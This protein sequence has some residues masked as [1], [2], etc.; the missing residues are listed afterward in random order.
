M[1]GLPQAGS[2]AY[3]LL[4]QGLVCHGYYKTETPGFWQHTSWPISF[5]L[6]VDD[7]DIKYI[8]KQQALHL[9][10][11]LKN[12]SPLTLTRPAWDYHNRHVNN[13]I[14]NLLATS[15]KNTTTKN[16]STYPTQ[17]PQGNTANYP[18]T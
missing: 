15:C 11:I 16:N 6:I 13:L 9:I 2:I 8:G 1:Y 4:K 12:T 14:P 18:T 10:R 17:N 7:F 5:T 3:N